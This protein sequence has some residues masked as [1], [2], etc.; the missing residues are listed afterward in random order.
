MTKHGTASI[1]QYIEFQTAVLRQL[2]RP[3]ECDANVLDGRLSNQAGLKRI[4]KDALLPSEEKLAVPHYT[5]TVDYGVSLAD[6]IAAGKYDWTNSDITAK[7]FPVK[8][9]GK[10]EVEIQLVHFDRVMESDDVIRELDR[11][12]LRPA[13][14]EELLAF[15]AKYPDM[16]RE[17]PIVALKTVWQHANGNRLVNCLRRY[18]SER[19]LSLYWFGFRWHEFYRFAAV[20]R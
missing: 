8:G 9:E 1:G 7:H 13:A 11:Q 20:R 17:F 16:Q 3:K 19:R 18:G 14:I 2:P 4:L 15:G 5:V 10:A 6:M 12:G